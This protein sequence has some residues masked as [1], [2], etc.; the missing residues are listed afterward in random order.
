VTK[1]SQKNT[2]KTTSRPDTVR[3]QRISKAFW[4]SAAF[5]SAIELG[6]FTAISNGND[7]VNPSTR[8]DCSWS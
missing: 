5:M 6:I 8:N 2:D 1:N 3:L 7:N 4:E